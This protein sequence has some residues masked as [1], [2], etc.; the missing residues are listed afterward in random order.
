[1]EKIS[2][3]SYELHDK[4]IL[5]NEYKK[6]KEAESNM[7]NDT[8]CKLLLDK[9]HHLQE[10]YVTNKSNEVLSNLHLAKLKLD[11]NNLVKEYKKAYKDYQILIGKITDIVFDG[12]SKQSLIDKIIRAK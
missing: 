5:S 7:L 1:M 10:V 4:L 6:L 9:F 8:T 2:K 12:F 11:E 3:L